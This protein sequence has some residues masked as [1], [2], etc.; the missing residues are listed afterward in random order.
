MALL[1]TQA[2]AAAKARAEKGVRSFEEML[3][4][5]LRDNWVGGSLEVAIPTHRDMM[6]SPAVRLCLEERYR[7]AG[8]ALRFEDR[9]AT[10]PTRPGERDDGSRPACVVAHF[11]PAAQPEDFRPA[12]PSKAG[13]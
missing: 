9:P 4:E 10:P 11:R 1:Y 3:D 8:W 5:Y 12:A 6:L 2:E 13:I 7:A